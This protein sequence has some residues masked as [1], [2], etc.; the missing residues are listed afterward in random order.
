M[1]HGHSKE[2]VKKATRMKNI[3]FWCQEQGMNIICYEV[4]EI[5]GDDQIW[6][7]FKWTSLV[8]E[9]DCI[10]V[11]CRIKQLCI[12]HTCNFFALI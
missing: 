7:A 6:Y 12:F 11:H 4:V 2:I 1:K 8:E 5:Y 10:R 3:V 9:K